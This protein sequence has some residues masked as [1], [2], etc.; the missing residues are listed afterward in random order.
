LDL[1]PIDA[2]DPAQVAWL[3]T[4]VWPEQTERLA[5]LQAAVKIAATVKPR[6]VRVTDGSRPSRLKFP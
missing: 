6:I 1:S 2:S 3:E 5:N 4:L